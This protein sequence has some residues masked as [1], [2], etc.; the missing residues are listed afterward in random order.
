VKDAGVAD[1]FG[2]GVDGEVRGLGADATA[3]TGEV[4]G[5]ALAIWSEALLVLEAVPGN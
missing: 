2:N 4:V 5:R 1:G 3:S